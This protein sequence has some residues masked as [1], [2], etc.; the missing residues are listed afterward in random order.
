MFVDDKVL[1]QPSGF[2]SLSP[3]IAGVCGMVNGD[4]RMMHV[5]Q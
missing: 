5:K 1:R 2:V 4:E 3:P